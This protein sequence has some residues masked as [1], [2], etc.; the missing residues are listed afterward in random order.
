ME[1]FKMASNQA[2]DFLFLQMVPVIG[3]SLKMEK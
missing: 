3:A 2:R 1:S